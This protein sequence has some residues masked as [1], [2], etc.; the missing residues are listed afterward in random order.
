VLE[1]AYGRASWNHLATG[2]AEIFSFRTGLQAVRLDSCVCSRNYF[3][4]VTWEL[5]FLFSLEQF[6]SQISGQN[7]G[8]EFAK[9]NA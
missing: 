3:L 9:R 4:K 2:K 6:L 5:S 7:L 8:S 1:V